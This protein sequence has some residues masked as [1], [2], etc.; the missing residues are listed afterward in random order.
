VFSPVGAEKQLKRDGEEQLENNIL[1]DSVEDQSYNL[2][3]DDAEERPKNHA[4]R[5][6]VEEHPKNDSE[7]NLKD[8]V[9]E[10]PKH[11]VEEDPKSEI[12]D[13]TQVVSPHRVARINMQ[14]WLSKRQPDAKLGWQNVWAMLVNGSMVYFNDERCLHKKGGFILGPKVA[15]RAFTSPAARDLPNMKSYGRERPYGFVM[16][17]GTPGDTR[18]HR[19]YFDALD[20]ASLDD[21]L[22][23]ITVICSRQK[24]SA[25]R[26]MKSKTRNASPRQQNTAMR[27]RACAIPSTPMR[28]PSQR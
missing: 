12:K 4:L 25:E 9:W 21:W 2:L 13:V 24:S 17:I 27:S 11:D 28:S 3:R 26:K 5:R 19:A 6:D 7:E 20:P 8:D 18:H 14:G 22:S 15:V 1:R 10:K 23:S 16:D